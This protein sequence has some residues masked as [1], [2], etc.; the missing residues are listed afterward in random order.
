MVKMMDI[1]LVDN[2]NINILYYQSD[3][4][5]I[6]NDKNDKYKSKIYEMITSVNVVKGILK[7][8]MTDFCKYYNVIKKFCKNR[9]IYGNNYC[10][11]N[12]I[13]LLVMTLKVYLN[14]KANDVEFN[15][16][17]DFLYLFVKYYSDF[18]YSDIISL[19]DCVFNRK[20]PSD[21]IMVVLTPSKPYVNI[22]RRIT[23]QTLHIIINEFNMTYQLMKSFPAQIVSKEISRIRKI[24]KPYV[25]VIVSE[26]FNQ[27]AIQKYKYIASVIWKVFLKLTYFNPDIQW[28]SVKVDDNTYTYSYKFGIK[29][30]EFELIVND[31]N[32]FGVDYQLIN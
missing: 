20:Y 15:C 16:I 4:L 1:E 17:Y 21:N 14:S 5:T 9:K 18:N 10:Y 6:V 30:N 26:I 24:E 31:L 2:S 27:N 13:S 23:K 12:G 32:K 11:L 29:P 7:N 28:Q 8:N 25:L 19:N 3:T 22:L